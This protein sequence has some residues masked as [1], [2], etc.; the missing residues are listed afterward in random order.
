MIFRSVLCLKGDNCV[1]IYLFGDSV[2]VGLVDGVVV[3]VAGPAA[4]VLIAVFEVFVASFVAAASSLLLLLL[5]LLEFLS[6]GGLYKSTEFDLLT[7]RGQKK[8]HQNI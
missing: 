4:I 8:K 1:C 6:A 2:E 3:V 7:E 5:L